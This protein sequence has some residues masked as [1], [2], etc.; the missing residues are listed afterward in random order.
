M[1]HGTTLMDE[2]R[3]IP[4]RGAAPEVHWP[5]NDYSRIPYWLYH[6][7]QIYAQEQERIFKGPTWSFLGLEAEIPNP[8]DFR[9]SLIGDTPVIV[10]RAADGGIHAMVNRCA[11]TARWCG[12]SRAATRA[13]ISASITAGAMVS[14]AR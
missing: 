3:T 8:G 7:P 4:H 12:A 5:R 13:S 1:C 9:T 2:H 14:T 6:D 11:T 10:D